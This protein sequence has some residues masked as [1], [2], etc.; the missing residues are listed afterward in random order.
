M[1]SN[2]YK[3]YKKG[4]RGIN[5]DINPT[6]IDL[7]NILRPDDL[8]LCTTID[9]DEKEF[10]VYFDHPFSPVNTLNEQYYKDTKNFFFKDGSF[11]SVKSKSIDKIL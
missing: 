2:T 5:L 6:S 1:Y 4:W 10:K 7:F 3:L 8:N 9:D 11:E